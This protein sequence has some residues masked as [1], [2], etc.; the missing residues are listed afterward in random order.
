MTLSVHWAPAPSG[1]SGTHRQHPAWKRSSGKGHIVLHRTVWCGAVQY[2][3]GRRF[4]TLY[5]MILYSTVQYTDRTTKV[6]FV[7][8]C[9]LPLHSTVYINDTVSKGLAWSFL[10]ILQC[11]YSTTSLVGPRSLQWQQKRFAIM[12]TMVTWWVAPLVAGFWKPDS[13]WSY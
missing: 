11:W 9:Q 12:G 13:I 3:T 8:Y 1:L 4:I 7:L 5:C 10:L 6:I 2:D